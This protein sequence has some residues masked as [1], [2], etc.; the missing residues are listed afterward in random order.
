M[1]A[2]Q[3]PPA[4]PAAGATGGPPAPEARRMFLGLPFEIR[5]MFQALVRRP[6]D[7]ANVLATLRENFQKQMRA[8]KRD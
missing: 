7:I 6:D 5:Q 4:I 8:A 1:I 3:L 2:V